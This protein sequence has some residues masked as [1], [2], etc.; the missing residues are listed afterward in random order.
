[1]TTDTEAARARIDREIEGRTCLE[2]MERNATEFGERPALAWRE[3]AEW[4][5]ASWAQYRQS[6]VEAAMGMRSLGLG[7]GDFVAIMTRNIPQHVIAD[8]AA[9][10]AAA[11]GVSVYN[12]LASDQI[13]YLASNCGAKIAVLENRDF[14]KRWEEVRSQLP[15]LRHIVLIEDADDFRHVDGVLSWDELLE[16]GRA[17]LAADPEILTRSMAELRPDDPATLVYTSG[18][19]GPP[20]GVVITHRNVRWSMRAVMEHLQLPMH[21]RVVSYLP[22]AHV[23]ERA[24]SHAGVIERAGTAYFCP[25]LPEALEVA[26][27][28]K[29]HL[30]LGVPRVWEKAQAGILAAIA[31]ETSPVRRIL[32]QRAIDVALHAQRAARNGSPAA[33]PL[34][35]A[36]AAF[37]RIVFSKIRAKLGLDRT[38][39]AL[40]GSAPCPE[41]V[42]EFFAAI[43]LPLHDTWGMTE[44]TVVATIHRPGKP[45]IGTVGVPIPG[46]EIKIADDGEILAR[47]G[48]VTAGYFKRPE[49]TAET[50]ASDG[51]VHSGDLGAL[52]ADGELRIT[53]RKKEIIITAGGKNISPANIEALIKRHPLIGH[54]CVVGDA[55]P[56]LTT[57][58]VLDV[59]TLP[60]WAAANGIDATGD[61]TGDERVR[62]EVQRAIDTANRS[63]SKVESIKK[64][65]I[66]S[67][68]WTAESG[69]LTPSLK[70][71]RSVIRDRYA[72][73][74][75]AMYR[76]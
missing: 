21:I 73:D 34:G 40:T 6:A 17:A 9:G 3:G 49:E 70:L 30:F 20:K 15:E 14:M 1:M 55:K 4:K 31:A 67:A 50:Y 16:K 75:E 22:L 18:T 43:G 28:A 61:L 24:V 25:E 53:G 47:G 23:A 66:L 29:P 2:L 63:L 32:A 76:G 12:T 11:T 38:R 52:D 59:E 62:A 60:G 37:D 58:I 42:H 71:K 57:L 68:D 51:W 39:I 46:V 64:F 48:I 26:K 33:I 45:K 69:E 8:V 36:R 74:I 72:D 54:A 5:T 7:H 44:L 35:I 41:H 56:Y 13:A 19:T 65:T 10:Y 27:V